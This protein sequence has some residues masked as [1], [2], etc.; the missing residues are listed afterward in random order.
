MSHASGTGD[1]NTGHSWMLWLGDYTRGGELNVE[2]G[3]VIAGKGIW[4]RFQGQQPHWN[5]PHEGGVKHSV[6]LYRS[7]RTPKSVAM[8]AAKK[9]RDD[10]GQAAGLAGDLA[11]PQGLVGEVEPAG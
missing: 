6:I 2:D 4:H 10:V 1:G 5:T 3:T 11:G 7:N 9:R 8:R